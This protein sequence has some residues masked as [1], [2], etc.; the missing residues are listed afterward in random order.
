MRVCH[1]GKF[2]PPACG[3][4]ETHLKTLATAQ[5]RQGARVQ[6][7]CVN[8][9]D[10]SGRDV[11]WERLARTGDIEEWDDSVSLVRLG[12]LASIARL[13]VCPGLL[14]RLRRLTS[15]DFDLL[16]LHVPNPTML[17]ALAL[18]KPR[19]PWVITYHSDVVKQRILARLVRPFEDMVF[20][21]A[22][23][24][25]VSS[26]TY[27]LGSAYLQRHS[28]KL[29]VIPFG[30]EL[31]PLFDP[32]S[33]ALTAAAR[34][35]S[36]HGQPLWLLVGRLVYYKGI[37]QALQ[38]LRHVPG[39]LVIVGEGPLRHELGELAERLGVAERVVWLGRLPGAE[40]IGAFH[41]ATALWFPSNA[42]S[43]AFGLVQIEAM[44]SGCPVINTNIAGS[45]VAW[46][47]RHE[48]TG[49]TVPVND[50]GALAAAANRLL[51]EPGLRAKLS[52]EARRRAG[53]EFGQDQMARR[54]L[55]IYERV[56]NSQREPAL[57]ADSVGG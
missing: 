6:V 20:R 52:R 15:S 4:I 17:L 29:V 49:L 48:E 31:Q 22:G 56:V 25:L 3:G 38:A 16:H 46:V 39:K 53:A 43:E 47:S 30:I 42:R 19:L 7:V 1:L 35:R 37:D 51:T 36:A 21:Q 5:S 40:L 24:V 54:T 27:P 18:A 14:S 32:T 10:R 33:E 41:A 13:D 9:C 44:A 8:H 2:Y 23:A 11:T 45:G 50:A 12:R 28:D 55:D 57:L 34:L 26:P